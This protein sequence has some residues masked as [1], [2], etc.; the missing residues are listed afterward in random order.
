MSP[1]ADGNVQQH[2]WTTLASAFD[3][4]GSFEQVTSAHT[5]CVMARISSDPIYVIKEK[6]VKEALDFGL[7][8]FAQSYI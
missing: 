7:I 4:L 8:T 2:H 5:F 6:S 3:Q 1:S